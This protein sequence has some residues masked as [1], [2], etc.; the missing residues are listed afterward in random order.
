MSY[1]ADTCTTYF[2]AW[3]GKEEKKDKLF[4]A[5]CLGFTF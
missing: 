3:G 1:I 2:K 4:I 5:I